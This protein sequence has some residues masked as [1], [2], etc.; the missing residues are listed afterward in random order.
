MPTWVLFTSLRLLVV[1]AIS[2]RRLDSV[3]TLGAFVGFEVPYFY[4]W[5]FTAWY[6]HPSV[7]GGVFG[8]LALAFLLVLS[9]GIPA[10]L[11]LLALSRVRY[12]RGTQSV[13]LTRSRT[14][15]LLP[16]MFTLAV[17]QGF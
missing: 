11:L 10:A 4:A 1:L 9:A 2:Y 5:R 6:S 7:S 13:L 15:L 3:R 17:I 14:A 12:F 8:W 16:A